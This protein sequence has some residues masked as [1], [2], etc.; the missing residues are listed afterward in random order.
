MSATGRREWRFY[1]DDMIDFAG[2]VLAYTH[3]VGASRCCDRR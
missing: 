1:L 3:G 2:K